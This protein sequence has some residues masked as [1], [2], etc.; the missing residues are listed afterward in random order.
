MTGAQD[1]IR[2][3]V[4]EW[5]GVTVHPHRFGGIEF[6]LG[7]RELGHI[8]GDSLLDIPFPMATRHELVNSYRVQP[9]HVLP[10]SG[11]ISFYIKTENDIQEGIELLRLSFDI[12]QKSQRDALQ[13]RKLPA[14]S[15]QNKK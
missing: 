2:N 1:K 5:N 4:S 11:W 15:E 8:H 13:R 10:E 9:H 6:R 12:A 7:K 14:I 3:A